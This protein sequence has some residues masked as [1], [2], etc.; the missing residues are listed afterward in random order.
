[1]IKINLVPA[2][3]L[4]KQKQQHRILQVAV[5]AVI[6]LVIMAGISFMHMS[7]AK[8][9][10]ATLAER[11]QRLSQ[12]QAVIQQVK[13]LE[14]ERKLVTA[15]LNAITGLA[16]IR[17]IYTYF[18]QDLVRSLPGGI[19]ILSLKTT[20]RD[21]KTLDFSIPAISRSA[22]DLSQWV[23]TL[24]NSKDKYKNVELGG[25]S[26]ADTATGKTFKFPIKA[27]Y[28]VPK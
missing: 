26:I 1:M 18:L 27:T 7:K 9:I 24:N 2:D 8:N 22:E 11:E 23:R 21:A 6:F 28:L 10:E 20:T 12:L 16:K 13:L 14:K 25:I 3:F 19:R 5:V 4:A 17:L 15:H